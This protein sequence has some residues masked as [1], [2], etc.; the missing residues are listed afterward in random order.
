MLKVIFRQEAI[1]DLSNIWEYTMLE[2][3]ITQADNYY[4]KLKT[5]CYE[6]GKNPELGRNYPNVNKQRKWH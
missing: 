2:W 5:A 3:S 4:Q 1:D 6:L